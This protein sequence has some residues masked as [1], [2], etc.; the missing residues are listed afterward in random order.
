MSSAAL[1][2]VELQGTGYTVNMPLPVTQLGAC[3]FTWHLGSTSLRCVCA[4][5]AGDVEYVRAFDRLLLPI[6][7]EFQP[8]LVLLS[9]GLH[10]H[11]WSLS[12]PYSVCVRRLRLRGRGPAWRHAGSTQLAAPI[13]FI[14]FSCL[15]QVSTAAFGYFTGMLMSPT[16]VRVRALTAVQQL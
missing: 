8:D 13:G 12:E 16:I 2:V 9:A 11:S 10:S 5:C 7:R 14:V 4:G 3:I 1:F 6:A 15:G